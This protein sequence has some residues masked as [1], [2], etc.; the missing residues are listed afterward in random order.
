MVIYGIY[1]MLFVTL[2]VL[3]GTIKVKTG[4]QFL[5]KQFIKDEINNV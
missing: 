3:N 5:C 2:H 4:E 1:S